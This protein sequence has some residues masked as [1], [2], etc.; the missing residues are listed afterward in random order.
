MSF[1]TNSD[2][3]KLG[4][5]LNELITTSNELKF[6]VGFFYFSGIRELY[7]S[8]KENQENLQVK[9][10]IGLEI[11]KLIFETVETAKQAKSDHQRLELFFS[12]IENG[13]NRDDMDTQA[14]YEQV[15]FFLELIRQD[16]IIIRKTYEPN[17][18]KLYIFKMDDTHKLLRKSIFITGSSN[19]TSPGLKSQQEFNVEISDFGT[20]EAEEYFDKLWDKA[21]EI[22]EIPQYKQRLLD[23]VEM[24]TLVAEITPFEAYTLI[25]KSYL[26]TYKNNDISQSLLDILAEKGYY[27]LKYQNDAVKQALAVIDMYGGVIIADVVGLGKSIIAS[28]IAKSLDKRGLVICPPGLIGDSN[29]ESGW[30]KYVDDFQLPNWDVRSVGSVTLESTLEFVI[31]HPDIEVIIIDEVHRFRNQDTH[32]YELLQNICRNKIVIQ[33]TATP[34]SNSP[35]DIFSLLKLFIVPGQSKITLDNDL[36]FRF[37][38]YESTFK[39]LSYVRKYHNSSDVKKRNRAQSMYI[40]LFG[41]DLIDIRNVKTRTRQIAHLIRSVIEPIMIRRNR[42]DIKNDPEYSKE[43]TTLSRVMEPCECFFDLTEKQSDFYDRV[44]GEY[45]GEDGLFQGAIYTPFIFEKGK[46]IDSDSLDEAENFEYQFQSNLLDFMKRLLVKRFESTF[47]SFAK[48]LSNFIK[49]N[50]KILTFIKKSNKYV[51]D[52]KLIDKFYESDEDE[53]ELALLEFAEKLAELEGIPTRKQKIY[54][55]KTFA[56][57]KGFIKA[58]EDD[59]KL[60]IRIQKELETLQLVEHDPKASSLIK[61]LNPIIKLH[62]KN[63]P[64]RKIIVF[65]EYADSADDIASKLEKYYPAKVLKSSRMI[66]KKEY[67]TILSNF[68]ASCEHQKDDYQILVA[69]DKLSEGFNLNRAG[70]IFNYDIPWNPTRV[71]QRVGRINR[72]GKRVFADLYIYNYFPTIQGADIV[73]SRETAAQKMYMIHNTLGEDAQIFESDEE[74]TASEL[75]RKIM[76]NPEALEQE[77]FLTTIRREYFTIKEKYPELIHK[78]EMFPTRLKTAKAFEKNEMHVFMKKGLGF[79]VRSILKENEVE[80]LSLEEVLNNIQCSFETKRIPFSDEF[81]RHYL[82]IKN[83]VP[84]DY[85]KKDKLEENAYNNLQTLLCN[86]PDALRSLEPFI[87]TLI[88]DMQDF[89]TLSRYT[90][91]QLGNLQIQSEKHISEVK[92]VLVHISHEMGTDYL[93]K[94]KNRIGDLKNEII[95]AVEN[96]C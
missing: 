59:R 29:H 75:Y 4:S 58:I 26:D 14:F 23:T 2:S 48:S 49:I 34:F 95:I 55:L 63:E 81:W 91:R 70:A 6:L 87:A 89:H 32:A 15:M 44:I 52:R 56:D 13:L 24:N 80:D 62:G 19:L 7:E 64:E 84:T 73:K 83:Y 93:D 68:D 12:S 50:D 43:V 92:K 94:L 42:I 27:N 16:K 28:M 18:A 85:S 46:D 82:D 17:H 35:A 78:L 51:L 54:D 1:I 71:I 61:L 69:T 33:L 5:R 11:D 66:S 76:I 41:S 74:V 60:F 37:K 67:K 57:A 9:I 47:Y 20:E 86:I 88:E 40:N 21:I 8:L 77:N 3:K 45:F 72:I 36:E 96:Q 31:K 10:L 30:R 79:F 39:K 90:L 53:I 22:T 38:S 65:T 25:L